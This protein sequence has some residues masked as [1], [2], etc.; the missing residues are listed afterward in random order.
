M[1]SFSSLK[2][3][4][5]IRYLASGN[6][7]LAFKFCPFHFHKPHGL[8]SGQLFELSCQL[9]IS[10]G[11]S[12]VKKAPHHQRLCSWSFVSHLSLQYQQSRAIQ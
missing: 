7:C 6:W 9:S 11:L 2:P 3:S 4:F 1:N 10:V 12:L 8:P 5:L